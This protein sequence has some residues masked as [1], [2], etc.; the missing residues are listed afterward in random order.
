MN[1]M[2]FYVLD[3]QKLTN[4]TIPFV[5]LSLLDRH[6]YSKTIS[7]AIQTSGKAP[8]A[9]ALRALRQLSYLTP[10]EN[11]TG[12][13]TMTPPTTHRGLYGMPNRGAKSQTAV[14]IAVGCGNPPNEA[15][16]SV[17]STAGTRADTWM[18]LLIEGKD[19]SS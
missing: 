5:L 7:H 9:L 10:N 16:A 19:P 18:V 6:L 11:L 3:K 1:A 15:Q 12:K 2:R 13:P 4:E 17:K 8:S 14:P